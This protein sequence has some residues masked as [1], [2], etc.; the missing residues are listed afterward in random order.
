MAYINCSN[1][2]LVVSVNL[3]F[4]LDAF[5]IMNDIL[6]AICQIIEITF[7]SLEVAS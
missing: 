4:K 1:Y 5:V 2:N 6:L 3:D 7:D